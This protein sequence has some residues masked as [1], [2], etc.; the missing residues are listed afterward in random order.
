MS[1]W[2]FSV[3]TCSCRDWHPI[4]TL[5]GSR[6]YLH[7]K[8]SPQD[9]LCFYDDTKFDICPELPGIPDALKLGI[10]E[11]LSTVLDNLSHA[12]QMPRSLNS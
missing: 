3:A 12:T 1:L 9:S 5:E 11:D 8:F 10:I 7:L 6:L 4:G 2:V